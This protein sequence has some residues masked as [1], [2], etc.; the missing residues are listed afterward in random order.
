MSIKHIKKVIFYS[1]H[2]CI[3]NKISHMVYP[4]ISKKWGISKVKVLNM[5][6][7]RNTTT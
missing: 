3:I 2:K 5:Y 7:C 6:W 4:F 1:K